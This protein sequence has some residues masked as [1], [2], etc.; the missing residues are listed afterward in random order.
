MHAEWASLPVKYIYG[1][2]MQLSRVFLILCCHR[3]LSLQQ[4]MYDIFS[5]AEV[6]SVK[7][8]VKIALSFLMLY[9]NQT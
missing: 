5:I 6:L 3:L 1:I 9:L 7:V 8:K 4:G 2:N